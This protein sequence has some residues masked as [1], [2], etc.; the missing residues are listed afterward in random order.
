MRIIYSLVCLLCLC[1]LQGAP[2]RITLDILRQHTTIYTIKTYCTVP[3][4][5]VTQSNDLYF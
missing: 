2:K 4:P 3:S 5:T 1:S